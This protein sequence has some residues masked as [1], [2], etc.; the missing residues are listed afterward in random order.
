MRIGGGGGVIFCNKLYGGLGI[1][2]S[3]CVGKSVWVKLLFSV[4]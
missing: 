3:L 2:L 1:M 4:K